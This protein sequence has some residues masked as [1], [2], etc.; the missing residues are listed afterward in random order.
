MKKLNLNNRVSDDDEKLIS[1]LK[2]SIG[3]KPSEEFVDNTLKKFLLLE[4]KEKRVHEPLKSPLYMMLIIGLI[5]LAPVFMAFSSQIS[6]PGP[7]LE[8]GSLIE[9]MSF[10]LD[11]WYTLT[12]MLLVLVLM[13]V[14]WIELGLVNFRTPFV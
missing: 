4:T 9:N 10:Q 12:P 1:L 13:F 3:K 2:T 6:L 8:L 11:S 7:G 5:L 14:V